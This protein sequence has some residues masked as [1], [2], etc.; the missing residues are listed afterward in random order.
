V[1]GS[2]SGAEHEADAVAARLGVTALKR[3]DAT[4]EAVCRLGRDVRVLHFADH[5]VA[6]AEE[7]R[8]SFLPLADERLTL[9]TAQLELLR[10]PSTADPRFWAAFKLTGNARNPL[11]A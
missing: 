5:G 7:P 11:T 1:L 9:R 6:S 2:V 4:L 3:E 10:A 8:D